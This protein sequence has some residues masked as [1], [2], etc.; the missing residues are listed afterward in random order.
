[1]NNKNTPAAKSGFAI[2]M[3][4]RSDG[5][6]EQTQQTDL[7]FMYDDINVVKCRTHFGGSL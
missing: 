3:R 7:Y 6:G 4:S 1:M 5:G 2:L